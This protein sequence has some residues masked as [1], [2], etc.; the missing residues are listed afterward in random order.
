MNRHEMKARVWER[1]VGETLACGTGA[2]AMGVAA[3]LLKQV[4]NPV[5]IL[6]PGGTLRVEWSG[7]GDVWLSG[8]VETVFA[9]EWPEKR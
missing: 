8:P 5:D 1:G 7:E 4:D 3:L 2:C 6:L 9:G